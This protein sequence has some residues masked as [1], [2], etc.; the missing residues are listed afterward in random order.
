V[1]IVK[2]GLSYAVLLPLLAFLV[3][4]ALFFEDQ[5]ALVNYQDE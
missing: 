4:N 3:K 1:I 5:K 2:Q